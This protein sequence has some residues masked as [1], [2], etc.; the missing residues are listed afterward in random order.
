MQPRGIECSDYLESRGCFP[1]GFQQF[2]QVDPFPQGLAGDGEEPGGAAVSRREVRHQP[3]RHGVQQDGVILPS[4][5]V[6]AVNEKAAELETL[7]DLFEKHLD[8]PS[9]AIEIAYGSR[10]PIHVVGDENHD[11]PGVV[12][13][14]PCFD[15]SELHSIVPALQRDECRIH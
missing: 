13:F 9:A 3:Q 4:Y 1:I 12:H 15:A 6:G 2:K 10:A 8:V 5:R 14:H 7:L 11:P